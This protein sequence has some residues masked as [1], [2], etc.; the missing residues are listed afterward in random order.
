MVFRRDVFVVNMWWMRGKSWSFGGHF[1]DMKS[2]A[3]F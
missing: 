2:T 1:S 3:A